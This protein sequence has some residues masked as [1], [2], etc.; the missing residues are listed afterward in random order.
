[1]QSSAVKLHTHPSVGK[2]GGGR[3]VGNTNG[4]SVAN[5]W[6]GRNG[7]CGCCIGWAIVYSALASTRDIRIDT[8]LYIFFSSAITKYIL[9]VPLKKTLISFPLTDIYSD[10]LLK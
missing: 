10:Q 1:M 4:G 8:C 5:G 7:F 9:Y 6:A 3:R 2:S